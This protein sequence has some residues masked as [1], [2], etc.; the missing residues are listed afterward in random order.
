[1]ED[2]RNFGIR[3]IGAGA[4]A[5]DSWLVLGVAFEMICTGTAIV[6]SPS[7]IAKMAG[8]LLVLDLLDK[9]LGAVTNT[10]P[11]SLRI[12]DKFYGTLFKHDN[13]R[14]LLEVKIESHNQ[15]NKGIKN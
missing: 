9:T 14:P 2:R 10:M 7:I 6:F 11:M 13:I 5:F 3:G 4:E 12:Y 15:L 8:Y 1:M